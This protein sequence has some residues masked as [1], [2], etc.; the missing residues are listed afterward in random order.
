MNNEKTLM[1]LVDNER[2]DKNTIHAF[3]ELY[4]EL[5]KM[6]KNTATKVLEVGLGQCGA[7]HC[8]SIKLWRDYFI[9][10]NVYGIDIYDEIHLWD[11]IKNDERIH[12]YTST[13]AYDE[14]NVKRLFVDNNIRFDIVLD[15]GSHRLDDMKKFIKLYSLLLKDDG[16][17]I[18]EDIPSITWLYELKNIVP[19]ELKKYIKT[20]DLRY[21]KSRYDDIVFTINKSV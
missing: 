14:K 13:D 12:I 19:D 18:I 2:T 1:D 4:E 11:G 20:Y 8:G 6:K 10:A 5:F 7:C 17:L 21:K 16:I 3:L 15:D 9:N